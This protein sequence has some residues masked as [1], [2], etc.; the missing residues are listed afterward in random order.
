MRIFWR[1]FRWGLPAAMLLGASGVLAEPQIGNV[2]QRQFNGAT[3]A[4]QASTSS[5]D[6]FYTQDVFAGEKVSTPA[7]GSTVMRFRDQTQLQVGANS[8]VVLDRFVYDPGTQADSGSINLAKGILR[9]I[10]GQASDARGVQLS[11]PTTTLTIRGTEFI[12]YVKDDG[13][14]TVGVI[15][16]AVD[17]KPCGNGDVAH[18]TSGQGFQV[19]TSCTAVPVDLASLPAD[20]ATS[21]DYSVDTDGGTAAG[22]LS[23]STGSG[24]PAGGSPS[25]GSFGKGHGPGAGGSAP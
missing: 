8:K 10:G 21:G 23:N 20:P 9:Y 18:A 14:T 17:V 22:G 12:V 16:G 3:G 25:G 11:T 15:A 4:R 24:P 13:T 5:Q 2:V 7:G 6:L 1:L 19:T